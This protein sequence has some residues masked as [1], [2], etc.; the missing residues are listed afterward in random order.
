[1]DSATLFYLGPCGLIQW[2]C[3]WIKPQNQIQ[4]MDPLAGIL[5]FGMHIN[6]NGLGFVARY[7]CV[8]E[9]FLLHSVR[10]K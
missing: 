6:S 2:Q 8:F 10:D 1:M 5:K 9:I 3:H 4:G 7:N